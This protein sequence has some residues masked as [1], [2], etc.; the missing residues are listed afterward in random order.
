MLNKKSVYIIFLFFILFA[1]CFHLY[2]YSG[3]FIGILFDTLDVGLFYTI[4]LFGLL[5]CTFAYQ[6][7]IPFFVEI[8]FLRKLASL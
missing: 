8:L 6:G 7:C 2:A 5:L 3:S 4:S 1:L